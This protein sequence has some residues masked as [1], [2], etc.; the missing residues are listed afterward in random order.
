MAKSFLVIGLGRFGASTAR[1]L[2]ELGH[3]VM[4]VDDDMGRVDALKN[5]VL[6]CMQADATQES[7]VQKLG[8]STY[9]SVVICIG[10]DLRTSILVTVLC[11]E[12]GAKHIVAKAQDEL[13]KKLLLKVGAD[14]VILP[15]LDAGM[16]LA[17][18]LVSA[19]ILDSLN[20][21]ERFSINEITVPEASLKLVQ[22]VGRLIRTESDYGRV[23]IL[24]N[25]V[26]TQRYG[27]QL[28]ACLPPFKRIG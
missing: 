28:L 5:D 23:T 9:D 24:D 7:V 22:A 13:Q 2:T 20:V 6:R 18:T 16:Q 15:E 10:T 4:A 26:K 14:R 17:R 8:V 1:T 21:T 3:H 19:N 27:K 12:N 25:R 11:H